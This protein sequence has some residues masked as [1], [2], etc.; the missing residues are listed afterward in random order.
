MQAFADWAAWR[1][2][3]VVNIMLAGRMDEAGRTEAL[4][5]KR[6]SDSWGGVC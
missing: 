4:R 3:V 2:G 1:Y 5:C 6:C